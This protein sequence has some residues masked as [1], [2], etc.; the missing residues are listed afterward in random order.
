MTMTV[1]VKNTTSDRVGLV[2]QSSQDGETR[3]A[4]G[5]T[6]DFTVHDGN[7]VTVSETDNVQ[8]DTSGAAA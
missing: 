7:A 2:L 8:A 6:Q 4:P 5:E 1:T 3:V